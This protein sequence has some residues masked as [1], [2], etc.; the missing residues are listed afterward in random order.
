MAHVFYG[1]RKVAGLNDEQLPRELACNPGSKHI[2]RWKEWI[3]HRY[4]SPNTRSSNQVQTNSGRRAEPSVLDL[5]F[6]FQVAK[7]VSGLVRQFD[8][9]TVGP[10]SIFKVQADLVLSTFINVVIKEI[11]GHVETLWKGD[12]HKEWIDYTEG[13]RKEG[14]FLVGGANCS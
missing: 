6:R 11:V 14:M 5:R 4:D 2:C 13:V 1:L 12:A 9:F 8:N 3:H 10:G 7:D